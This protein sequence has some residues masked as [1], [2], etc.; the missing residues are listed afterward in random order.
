MWGGHDV[1]LHGNPSI[2]SFLCGWTDMRG[3]DDALSLSF[4]LNNESVF[5]NCGTL[6]V[7]TFSYQN[8]RKLC[9]FGYVV[10]AMLVEIDGTM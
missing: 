1:H 6:Y 8:S 7:Q 5:L 4:L 3:Y 2:D 10:C 9:V